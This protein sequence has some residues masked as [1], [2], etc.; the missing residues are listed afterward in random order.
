MLGSRLATLILLIGVTP[1]VARDAVE[2]RTPP[3]KISLAAL[4]ARLFTD[5]SLSKGGKTACSSCHMPSRSFTDGRARSIGDSGIQTRR[6]TPTLLSVSRRATYFWDG[7]EA[8]F[9]AA[10][11][12]PLFDPDEMGNV[13]ADALVV[14]IRL[15]EDYESDFAR[16]FG[17]PEITLTRI[18]EA[19]AAYIR[20]I[21]EASRHAA[22][23]EK[24][25]LTSQQLAGRR[26]FSGKA[27]CGMCHAGPALTDEAFHNTGLAM[28]GEAAA[29]TGRF[30]VTGDPSDA[31]RFRTPSLRAVASTAPYMHNGAFA[32]LDMVIRL[33]ERGGGS[34]WVRDQ[35]EEADPV[36]RNMASV[37]PLLAPFVLTEDER[38]AL[39]AFLKKL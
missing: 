19:L 6:N 9:Q 3:E 34:P 14:R 5:P 8:E 11:Q 15:A 27:G 37:S 4:G 2:S 20:D 16:A 23:A 22:A 1:I 18:G 12:R 30:S 21:D 26:I 24:P 25:S 29:D 7:A 10:V 36:A 17:S 31:G 38:N 39:I 13:S 33:Y 28:P 35:A 32:D